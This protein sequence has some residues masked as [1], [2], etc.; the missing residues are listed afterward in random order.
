MHNQPGLNFLDALV[1][2]DALFDIF[3]PPRQLSHTQ[4]TPLMYVKHDTNPEEIM[5]CV[6]GIC[7][8]RC[9]PE[10]LSMG[11]AGSK[12]VVKAAAKG[13]TKA[14]LRA[15]AEVAQE[16]PFRAASR[17]APEAPSASAAPVPARRGASRVTT[18]PAPGVP[19]VSQEMDVSLIKAMNDLGPALKSMRSVRVRY[20]TARCQ[21][22]IYLTFRCC[23]GCAGGGQD[24]NS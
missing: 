12:E 5:P 19:A 14:N 9:S 16:A 6:S 7:N 24:C 17:P 11:Q 20:L 4:H 18:V 22:C 23:S 10:Q 3:L 21:L 15:A 13:A 8:G 1:P 2:G